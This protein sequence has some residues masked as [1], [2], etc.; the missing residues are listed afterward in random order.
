[1]KRE[2]RLLHDKAIESLVLSIEHFNRPSDHGRPEAVII[3]IERSFEHLLKAAIIHKGGRIREPRERETIGFD[4]CVRKCLTDK[5]V[6]CLTDEQALTIQII[7][8]LR[9]AAQHYFVEISEPQ[10]YMYAQAG[11]TLFGAIQ[12]SVFGLKL[13]DQLPARVLPVTTA[14]PH[15][16]ASLIDAEFAEVK[17][18]LKPGSRRRLQAKARLRSLAVL[19]ASVRGERSQPGEGELNRVLRGIKRGT[20]WQDLFPGVATLN[21]D[22]EGTGLNVTIRLT[23]TE[24]EPVRLV[25]EGTPGATVIAVKK[26]NELGFYSLGLNQLAE[27][28]GLS[29]PK[30]L[31]L[32]KHLHLQDDDECYR[33]I[34]IGKAVFKRYSSVAL[35]RLKTALPDVDRADVWK[36]NRPGKAA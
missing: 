5:T 11:V 25:P 24:G 1:M 32:I 17:Q 12:E 9:D 14:P 21:L 15:S 16:L 19:E 31:A 29:G 13:R 30:T 34:T 23:K 18:L 2:A 33:E 26:V 27:K 3:L 7:N 20:K 22:T 6:Q 28:L 35:D 8:S 10:L 4:K 36:A